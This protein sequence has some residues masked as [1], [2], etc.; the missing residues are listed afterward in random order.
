MTMDAALLV[1]IAPAPPAAG[2]LEDL[3]R[4]LARGPAAQA[5]QIDAVRAGDGSCAYLYLW[6]APD[7]P[8]GSAQREAV[9]AAVR[10]WA[11]R[12]A[13]TTEV[14]R[15]APLQD[16]EGASHGAMAGCHYA[17]EVDIEP[18]HESELRDWYAIEHLPG[19]AAVAGSVR[20]R[21]MRNLDGGPR[22]FACYD[23]E[24]RDTLSS[25]PWLAVRA[26]EWASRM[27]PRFLNT[28]RTVFERLFTLDLDRMESR[29]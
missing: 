6:F 13:G 8:P 11:A 15:L 10:A 5:R 21:R 18:E 12:G 26:T 23:L 25:A 28:R 9:D 20:A 2:A 24:S 1:R 19:L 22:S 17:V 14:V 3:S 27:R 16:L 4:E 7:R 29:A